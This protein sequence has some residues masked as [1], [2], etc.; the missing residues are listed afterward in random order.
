[1]NWSSPHSERSCVPAPA[2]RAATRISA[3]WVCDCEAWVWL[4]STLSVD[5]LRPAPSGNA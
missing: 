3:L 4:K 1:M 2:T 5:E